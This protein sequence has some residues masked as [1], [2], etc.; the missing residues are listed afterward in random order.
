MAIS[1]VLNRQNFELYLHFLE[2]G[3]AIKDT[4]LVKLALEKIIEA[5]LHPPQIRTL[6]KIIR[7]YQNIDIPEICCKLA[8]Q[9]NNYYQFL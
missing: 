5:Q 3:H 4:S 7:N 6:V 9:T 8:E 2:C 1:K